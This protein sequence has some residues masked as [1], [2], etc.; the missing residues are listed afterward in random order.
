MT[1]QEKLEEYPMFDVAILRH[2][3]T[4]YM[5]D[6]DV[7]AEIGG[8]GGTGS[9]VYRYRFTHCVQISTRTLVRD[10]IWQKSW[11][12]LFI[13]YQR[14]LEADTP[15]GFVWGACWS[16]AYPGLS[17]LAESAM[18][19][20]WSK[21]LQKPMHEVEIETQA[22]YLQLIFHDILIDKLSDEVSVIDKAIIP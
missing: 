19:E 13:D 9:G 6:Y 11:D 21:R 3:Y 14:W 10:E 18:A 1:V 8:V 15:I 12:D 2:G 4:S 22:F 17:Y 5:R 7:I 16:M 20:E